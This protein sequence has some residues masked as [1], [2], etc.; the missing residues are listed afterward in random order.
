MVSAPRKVQPYALP[1][2][3]AAKLKQFAESY[4]FRYSKLRLR[5]IQWF[6]DLPEETKLTA[7]GIHAARDVHDVRLMRLRLGW[8]VAQLAKESGVPDSAVSKI[9]EGQFLRDRA[10]V[11]AQLMEAMKS[12]V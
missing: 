11:T 7:M 12:H 6:V 9:E 10:A 1:P 8:T 4:G 3:V 5:I 2:E